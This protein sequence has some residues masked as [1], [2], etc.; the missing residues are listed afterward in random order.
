MLKFLF[1]LV[2]L[3]SLYGTASGFTAHQI[4]VFVDLFQGSRPPILTSAADAFADPNSYQSKAK[5]KTMEVLDGIDATQAFEIRQFYTLA[6][7]Y[8][9]TNGVPN[10]RTTTIIPG[11]PIPNW[12]TD[13]WFIDPNYCTWFGVACFD[14]LADTATQTA[15][16]AEKRVVEINLSENDLYG[17]FPNEISLIWASLIAIDLFENFF[18]SCVDYRW[19]TA[20]TNMVALFFGTTS[21]DRNGI[22]F[23]LRFMDQL[24]KYA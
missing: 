13:D 23:E 10:H 4:G 1:S 21:W 14:S 24:R 19:M 3:A 17:L 22:P 18:H 9:S 20:M 2:S 6:C 8:Y 7:L 5:A 11:E 15:Q 16:E 12:A